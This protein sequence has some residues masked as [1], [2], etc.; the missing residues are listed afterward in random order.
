V[1]SAHIHILIRHCI[2]T[3]PAFLID[4]PKLGPAYN[5]L[6]LSY[7]EEG[8]LSEAKTAFEQAIRVD[9]EYAQAEN[10]LGAL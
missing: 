8:R 4:R 2:G 10:N 1:F 3:A 7:V 9:P 6:G 5:A